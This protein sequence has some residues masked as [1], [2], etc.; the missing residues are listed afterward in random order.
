M[1]SENPLSDVLA[2][3]PPSPRHM[4]QTFVLPR[5][6]FDPEF[7]GLW[8]LDLQKPALF[9]GNHTLFGLT[10]APLMVEHLY[11][12]YGVMLRCLGDRG[13]F[14]VPLWGDFLI[15]NGMVLGTPEKCC[16]LMR[17]GQQP[18]LTRNGDMIPPLVRGLG[19][20]MLPRPQRYYFGFGPRIATAQLQGRAAEPDAVWE[21]REQV[22]RAVEHQIERL[23]R[24]R[25]EDRLQNWS[26]ARRWLAPLQH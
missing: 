19:P 12:Q 25:A 18:E 22:A 10:D 4:R 23:L 15:R 6:W 9:V 26:A 7:L 20:T 5:R 8:E 11:T 14:R 2:F 13:H 24:Y 16:A 3:T 21:L 1:S 17:A